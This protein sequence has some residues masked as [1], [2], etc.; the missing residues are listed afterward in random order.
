MLEGKNITKKFGGLLALNDLSFRIEN[1]EIVGLIGPNGSGKTTLFNT[2]SGLYKPDSGSLIMKDKDITKWKPYQIARLGLGRTFQIVQPFE[3]M[4]VL[5]NVAIGNLYGTGAMDIKKA[6]KTAREILQFVGARSDE[7]A[8][9]S[10]LTLAERKKLE[11]ARAL[12][13]KPDLL[14]LDEVF[15]GLNETEI[16]EAIALIFKIRDSMRITIFMVEHV[17]TAIMKT[18]SRVIV[19]NY[20]QKLA[21]GS[22][23]EVANDPKVVEAYLGGAVCSR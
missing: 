23:Q 15:A 1:D 14:L 4:T 20:G 22:P 10:E 8:M 21:E 13:T 17:L 19:L 6:S 7:N 18:C 2:I 9:A 3:E 11:I 16:K 5:Q 12:A